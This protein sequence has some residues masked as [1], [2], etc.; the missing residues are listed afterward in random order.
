MA[1]IGTFTRG[2]DGILSGTIRTLSLNVKARFVPDRAVLERKGP[3]PARLRRPHR[4]RRRL[5]AD[6][7]GQHRLSLGEAR[8]PVL[9]DADLC[10]PRRGRGRLRADL[11]ALIRRLR[12]RA[13]RGAAPSHPR[14]YAERAPAVR[15][16]NPRLKPHRSA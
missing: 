15:R 16:G 2:D 13:R 1:Q 4:D 11:V 6:L 14:N 12:R 10:Q 3:G 5:E 7:E 9:P 8:R